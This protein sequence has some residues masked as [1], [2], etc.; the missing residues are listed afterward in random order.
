M[1][2]VH[3]GI[4]DRRMWKPQVTEFS[5]GF[6]VVRPDLRGFGETRRGSVPY[7]NV[8][9]LE[10]LLHTLGISEAVLVGSSMGGG[11]VLDLALADP[12]RVGALVLAGP[13]PSGLKFEDGATFEGWRAA[14]AAFDRGDL[15]EAAQIEYEMWV[16]GVGRPVDSVAS[17]I[18]RLVVDMLLASYADPEVEQ[19]EGDSPAIHRLGEIAVPTLVVVGAHDR[20]DIL[21][22]ADVLA[23]EIAGARKVIVPRTA[24]LPNLE[25]PAVFN[26]ILR[27][28][29]DGL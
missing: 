18:Q 2:L 14:E 11:V 7:S 13:T 12:D 29:V 27:E 25:R 20:P 19:I 22:A 6:R 1:I 15:E 4:A 26:R 24:H 9:D 21:R 28:F 23:E 5:S 10:V 17:A 16:V 3:A 8:T